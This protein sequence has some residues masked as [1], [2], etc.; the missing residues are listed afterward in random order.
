[1]YSTSAVMLTQER[2]HLR[3]ILLFSF[4][5][6]AVYERAHSSGVRFGW[7]ETVSSSHDPF[8]VNQE[9]S[10]DVVSTA[11]FANAAH[12]REPSSKSVCSS[13]RTTLDDNTRFTFCNITCTLSRPELGISSCPTIRLNG[14][15]QELP[16]V[17]LSQ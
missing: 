14:Y 8:L 5:D 17:F 12:I 15:K 11:S 1:M 16:F 13:L 2:A 6:V 3:C 7:I 9:S 10:T 4:V